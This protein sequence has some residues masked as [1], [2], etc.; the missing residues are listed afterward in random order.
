MLLG[1][2]EVT[3]TVMESVKAQRAEFQLQSV[4]FPGDENVSV[5]AFGVAAADVGK[6][7]GT[8]PGL[9]LCADIGG[10]DAFLRLLFLLFLIG[11]C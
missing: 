3:V 11:N 4:P 10:T 1:K 5:A 8:R 7:C 2:E 6:G 9:G